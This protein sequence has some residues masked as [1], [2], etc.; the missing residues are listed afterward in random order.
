MVCKQDEIIRPHRDAGQAGSRYN[1]QAQQT[2]R[3]AV[4][5]KKLLTILGAIILV[6]TMG[7]SQVVED[8]RIAAEQGDRDAQFNLGNIYWHD[9]VVDQDRGEAVRWFRKAAEQGHVVA[10]FNLGLAYA[11]GKGVITDEREAVR[12]YRKAAKHGH[13][14]A[15]NNLGNLYW[16]REGMK[17]NVVEAY[18]WLS[19][20]KASGNEKAMDNLNRITWED[21]LSRSEIRSARKE[22]A[23]RMEA[24]ENREAGT[25]E[26]YLQDEVQ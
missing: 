24:I 9:W 13:V 15:Q 3:Q 16:N 17:R 4:N 21:H 25:V 12:W 7:C 19:I 6:M 11:N 8:L 26:D 2:K 18:I 14:G 10:Q 5:I 1:Y 20:A 22:A 23:R